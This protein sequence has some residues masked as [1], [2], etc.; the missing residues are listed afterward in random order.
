MKH[1]YEIQPDKAFWSKSVSKNFNEVTLVKNFQNALLKTDQVV[2][3]GSCFASNLIPYLESSGISYIRTE[4]IP[5]V[6]SDLGENLGYANFSA[7]YG[8][9]YTARQL[10]QLYERAMGKFTPK[11]DRWFIKESVIDPFRPGLRF[12]AKNSEEF[13]FLLKSHLQ[14]TRRA[15]ESADVFVFTLGL[16]EGWVSKVDGATYPACP[17]TISGE[18]DSSKYEFKNFTTQE[19]VDDLSDFIN[20]LREN[21]PKVK[22]IITVSPVPLVATAT[23]NHVLLATI[24]SKS[25]LRV[26][27]EAIQKQCENVFY[28]PAYEIITGP[29]ALESYFEADK[30]NVSKKGVD[31]VMKTLLTSCG[32]MDSNHDHSQKQQNNYESNIENFSIR[33]ANVECDEVMLDASID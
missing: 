28:F 7:S 17:G 8:N 15:F 22:F 13:D 30:R 9:I 19:I 11:E 32:L 27:A 21:N 14:A 31:L 29:Q 6:F 3:A 5:K 1:P 23:D 12:P 26:A 24:L 18:F 2:S 10:K 33:V 16:T 25:I 20:L 4:K